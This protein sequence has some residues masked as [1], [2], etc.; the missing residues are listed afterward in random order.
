[1]T[2]TARGFFEYVGDIAPLETHV[3]FLRFCLKCDSEQLFVAAWQCDSGLVGCCQ[4]CGDE[5]IAPFTRVN[6]E[7]A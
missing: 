7:V 1:M 5:R 3:Q 6:S 4:G 2:M